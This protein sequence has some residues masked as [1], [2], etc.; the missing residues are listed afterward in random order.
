[1]DKVL[2][3]GA[4]GRVGSIVL[5]NLIDLGVSVRASSRKPE[6]RAWPKGAEVVQADITKPETLG[7]ALNGIAKVFLYAK[8]EGVD[9]FV[10]AAVAAKVKLI[11]LLSSGAVQGNDPTNFNAQRHL[12]VEQA[13]VNSGIPYTFLRPGAFASNALYWRKQIKED[14]KVRIAYPQSQLAP[15]HEAD[16][17]AVAAKAL[18]DS[19]LEGATPWLTGPESISQAREVELIGEAIGRQ[20]KVEEL[21]PNTALETMKKFMPPVSAEVVLESLKRMS[22][23]SAAVSEEVEKITGRK[24]KNFATWA[25]DHAED[26]V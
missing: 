20:I 12:A 4:G 1:M 18:S 21:S 17:A 7:N 15:I 11:V 3:V 25:R 10:R 22:G 24:A 6:S 5:S 19:D 26:F 8:P 14:S 16:I 9:S 23:F 13:I 2:V